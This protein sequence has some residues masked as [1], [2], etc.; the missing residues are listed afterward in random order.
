MMLA[1]MPAD[2]E[3]Y[4]F[5]DQKCFERTKRIVELEKLFARLPD[6]E[7]GRRYASYMLDHY[8]WLDGSKPHG[9][10]S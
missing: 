5:G 2:R 4:R 9:S 7:L 3:L 1:L 6:S 10:F 8:A